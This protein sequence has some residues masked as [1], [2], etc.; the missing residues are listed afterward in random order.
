[1]LGLGE[2]SEGD[3]PGGW[4]VDKCDAAAFAAALRP[5]LEHQERLHQIN[6]SVLRE[7]ALRR[8][9]FEAMIRAVLAEYQASLV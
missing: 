5:L 1:V 2:G 3:C 4:L 8:C 7:A 6:P 9:S